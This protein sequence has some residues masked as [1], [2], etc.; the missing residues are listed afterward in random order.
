MDVVVLYNVILAIT[1]DILQ[2]CSWTSR[3]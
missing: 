1:I 2:L 3:V